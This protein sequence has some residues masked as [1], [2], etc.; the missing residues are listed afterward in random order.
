VDE[1]SRWSNGRIHWG[2]AGR[3]RK[4]AAY[5]AH[6]SENIF[7]SLRTN[8]YRTK[9]TSFGE[10]NLAGAPGEAPG[11]S[12]RELGS[13]F[14]SRREAL[15]FDRAAFLSFLQTVRLSCTIQR[16]R[17]D[18]PARHLAHQMFAAFFYGDLISAPLE[19]L[20]SSAREI[21]RTRI[22]GD[23]ATLLRAR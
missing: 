15:P 20:V 13:D 16:R 22:D 12:S 7:W 18:P 2:P 6:P 11:V 4:G 9:R 1:R 10:S 5:Q 21:Q 3:K 8:P 14:S 17:L 23:D 19:T